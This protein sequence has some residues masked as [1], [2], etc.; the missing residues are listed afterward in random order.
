MGLSL[1]LD[2]PDDIPASEAEQLKHVP[3]E[4]LKEVLVSGLFANG[5]ITD[6]AAMAC[7]EQTRRQFHEMLAR[8][9]VPISSPETEQDIAENRAIYHA[10]I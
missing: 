8:N 2:V 10:E 9:H 1:H 5:L 3:N 6:Q 4:R 7:M